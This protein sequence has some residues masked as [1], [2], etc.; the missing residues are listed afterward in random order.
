MLP[1]TGRACRLLL[2]TDA[3]GGVWTHALDLALGLAGRGTTTLLAV[4]GPSPDDAQR[5]AAVAVPGLELRETGL[6]LD[7]LAASPAEVEQ[8]ARG[9]AALARRWDAD[10]VQ[11]HA[12]ALALAPHPV[13]VVAVAHSCLATWWRA[14]RGAAPLPH[15]FTWRC[16]LHARGLALAAA[17]VTPSRAFA[18]ATAAAHGLARRPEVVPNGRTAPSAPRTG[19]PAP[20]AIAAGRLWD[21]AKDIATLD[22]AAA[23]LDLPVVA[24][25]PVTGPNDARFTARHLRL[26]GSLDAGTLAALLAERPIFVSTSRYEPFGLAVLE[27]AQAGCALVLSDIPT[28]R[29][30]WDGAAHFVAPGDDAALAQ[31]IRDLVAS[32]QHRAVLAAAAEERSRIFS[33]EAMAAGMDTIHRRLLA[34]A[35]SRGG[36]QAA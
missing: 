20:Y 28:F 7:W 11:L 35:P 6:A 15:D 24:A 19:A 26:T 10:L 22:R 14:M 1:V 12:P 25:G 8:A 9:V 4:L 30:L 34:E 17:V 23:R 33:I 31:A 3:V 29:E 27:A 16:R 13:P 2:T 5:G 18:D 32:P 21:E 36:H